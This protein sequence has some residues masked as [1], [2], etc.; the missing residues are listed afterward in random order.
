VST[1]V[2]TGLTA[3]QIVAGR[4]D[5]TAPISVGTIAAELG[6][7]LSAASRLCSELEAAGFLERAETYGAYRLGRAAIRLSGRAAAPYA[8]AVRFA[9]TLAAQQ[10]GETVCLAARSERGIRIVASVESLWTLH[11]PARVGETVINGQSAIALAMDQGG[12]H[13]DSSDLESTV[14]LSVEIAAPVVNPD[15]ERVAV[16]GV[17]MPANRAKQ[18]L[19]RSRRAVVVARKAIERAIEESQAAPRAQP[20]LRKADG[21]SVSA[22]EAAF[23][24][25]MHLADGGDTVA[26]TAR[27]TG[28]RADRTQRILDAC[29]LAGFVAA[30]SDGG[31]YRLGWIVHGWHRAATSP[32]LVERG[33]PIVAATANQTRTCAFITVLKGMRSFTLV[34]E[35]EMA[36][37]GLQMSPWLGRPHPMIGSDG[38]PTLVMDFTAHE[39]GELFPTRHTPHELGVFLDRVDTVVRDGVL[40]MQAFEDAGIVSISAPVRDASG[41][42]AAAVCIVGTTDYISADPRRFE[43][44]ART[45]AADVTA[46]LR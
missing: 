22:L 20:K 16:I 18:N 12:P 44:A 11:S 30:S 34:E 26:A 2:V 39:V 37:E 7:T 41:S 24:I 40:S 17:R 29:R 32:T 9:L 45:L 4:A 31:R 46:L 33:K 19:A 13:A 1:R 43:R 21:G 28:L 14:G 15:G 3:V 27:A 6:T 25:L 10:T 38:G 35:L 5:P 42:V 23:R 36:G 8:R